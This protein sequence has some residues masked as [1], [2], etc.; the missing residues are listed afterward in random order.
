MAKPLNEFGGWLYFFYIWQLIGLVG[1]TI[2]SFL[3][4]ISCISAPDKIEG[5]LLPVIIGLIFEIILLVISLFIILKIRIN[6]MINTKFIKN[7]LWID[8]GLSIVFVI[9]IISLTS[10]SI[11]NITLL[12]GYLRSG[13]GSIVLSLI[14]IL[15]FNYSKRVKQYY[16]R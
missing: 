7:L 4:I 12:A 14:W 3:S 10:Q 6:I 15:Y 13:F 11:Y 8:F 16:I 2:L 9:I 5:N 1:G